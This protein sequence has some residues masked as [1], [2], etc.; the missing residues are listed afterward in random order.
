MKKI[1]HLL[2]SFGFLGLIVAGIQADAA[3]C[4]PNQTNTGDCTGQLV[5]SSSASDI[6]NSGTITNRDAGSTA[7]GMNVSA[8]I[9]G[10]LFN[11]GGITISNAKENNSALNTHNPFAVSLG[12]NATVRSFLNS[13]TIAVTNSSSYSTADAS[14]VYAVGLYQYSGNTLKT[15]TNSSSISVSGAVSASGNAYGI[16]NFGVIGLSTCGTSTDNESCATTGLLK[17][18]G[19]IN[20]SNAGNGTS[21]GINNGNDGNSNAYISRIDNIG[22]IFKAFRPHN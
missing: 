17:N 20:V 10:S 5:L 13:G 21:R 12:G 16:G 4:T 14:A 7:L 1:F 15:L 2:V 3:S 11:S 9:S 8:A 19:S 6:G 22:S 18:S